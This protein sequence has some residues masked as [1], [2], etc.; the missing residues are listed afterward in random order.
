MKMIFGF[1]ELEIKMV[2]QKIFY[3]DLELLK[4]LCDL[5]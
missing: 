4:Y 2:H 1:I 3:D 5:I